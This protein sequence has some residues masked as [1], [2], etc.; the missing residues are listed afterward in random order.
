MSERVNL[1]LKL[2]KQINLF[3]DNIFVGFWVS[4][5]Q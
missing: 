1:I 3:V 4:N 5:L 2:M